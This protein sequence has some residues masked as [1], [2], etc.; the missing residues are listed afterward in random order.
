MTLVVIFQG[1]DGLVLA[2]DSRGTF[3]GSPRGLTIITDSMVKMFKLTKYVGIVVYGQGEL[4]A[5]LVI[6]VQKSLTPQDL[7][8]SQVLEKI[9]SI[10]RSK[11]EDWF[12]A[13]PMENRPVVGF[14][15]GGL[16]E[17]G[18]AKIYLLSSPLDFA[19]QLCV[20]KVALGGILQY[21]AYLTRRLYNPE[22]SRKHLIPL[23]IYVISET[24]T[25]DPRVGGP[26]RVA[27]ISMDKGYIELEQKY[28]EEVIKRNEGINKRLRGFFF[29]EEAERI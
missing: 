10:L 16:E 26:I 24:A 1:T 25:Q 8:V 19:P 27:E 4:A 14:I 21:A 18:S 22:M 2:A 12:K 7:Y 5:Q 20:T 23:A 28:I 13:I 3:I 9:R 11:Y 15:L 17:D 29:R 6:E